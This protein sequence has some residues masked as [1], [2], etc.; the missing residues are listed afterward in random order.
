M[1]TGIDSKE[2]IPYN[3]SPLSVFVE[4]VKTQQGS[5]NAIFISEFFEDIAQF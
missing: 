3:L 2:S 1:T 4:Q 5:L